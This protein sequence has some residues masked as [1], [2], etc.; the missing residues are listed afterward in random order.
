LQPPAPAAPGRTFQHRQAKG[1]YQT[2]AERLHLRGLVHGTPALLAQ[3]GD[4]GGVLL[5]QDLARGVGCKG[6]VGSKR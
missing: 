1:L 3:Q 5:L 6:T 2:E 4:Q